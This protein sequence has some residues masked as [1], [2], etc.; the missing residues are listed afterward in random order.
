MAQLGYDL[1]GEKQTDTAIEVF[2]LNTEFYPKSGN[3]YDVLAETYLS[4]GNKE[5]AKLLREGARSSARLSE[6]QGSQRDPRDPAQ[7]RVKGFGP[8]CW[9]RP[10]GPPARATPSGRFPLSYPR[11]DVVLF[12]AD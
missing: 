6:R 2:R 9:S 3:T 11:S 8:S 10:E 5:L 12:A 7:V 1:L 4:M